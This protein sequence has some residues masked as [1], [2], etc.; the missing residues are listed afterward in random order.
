LIFR[1][2]AAVQRCNAGRA[3]ISYHRNV[4]SFIQLVYQVLQYFML[5]VL[6]IGRKRFMYK[7]MIEQ[8]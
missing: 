1:R 6:V 2:V 5:V 7:I 8:F 3:G 4:L